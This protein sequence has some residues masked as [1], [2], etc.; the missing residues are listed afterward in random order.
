MS[1]FLACSTIP[2]K[3]SAPTSSPVSAIAVW[4]LISLPTLILAD[5]VIVGNPV[6]SRAITK[7][8]A[9]TDVHMANR[10]LVSSLQQRQ[11]FELISRKLVHGLA[12]SMVWTRSIIYGYAVTGGA[13]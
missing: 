5:I 9:A 6:M 12:A 11:T 2:A 13:K 8:D 1:L 3:P 10:Y 7:R 4:D